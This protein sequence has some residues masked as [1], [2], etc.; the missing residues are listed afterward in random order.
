MPI[1]CCHHPPTP[2]LVLV[3]KYNP[4]EFHP[5]AAA[6]AS[7][8]CCGPLVAALHFQ[9]T[10]RVFHP[11]SISVRFPSQN[12]PPVCPE[13]CQQP[14]LSR[15]PQPSCPMWSPSIPDLLKLT[16]LPSL[17]WL[18]HGLGT[19]P[20]AGEG[21][22]TAMGTWQVTPLPRKHPRGGNRQPR[23]RSCP[24]PPKPKAEWPN[25][26]QAKC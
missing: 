7:G 22:G 3:I 20:W 19:E 11:L 15:G 16:M 24:L 5:V 2:P 14:P 21:G 12:P 25:W 8:G 18:C 26:R 4:L 23:K 1:C 13:W 6:V 9:A 10:T 17:L